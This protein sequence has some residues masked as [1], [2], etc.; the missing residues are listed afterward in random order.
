MYGAVPLEQIKG[1]LLEL[2]KAGRLDKVR[3]LLL[4]IVRFDGMYLQ[5]RT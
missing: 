3:M 4:P 1:R 2:K 5:R